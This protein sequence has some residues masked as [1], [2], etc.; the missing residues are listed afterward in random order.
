MTV[1]LGR[2]N[3]NINATST[4]ECTFRAGFAAECRGMRL[5]AG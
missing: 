5:N 4:R 3:G 2:T 1:K